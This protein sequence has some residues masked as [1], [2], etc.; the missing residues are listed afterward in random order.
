MNTLT[1]EDVAIGYG[2]PPVIEELD[3]ELNTGRWIHCHGKNGVGKSTLLKVLAGFKNPLSGRL[4][5]NSD[6]IVGIDRDYYRRKVRYFGHGRA[7]FQDLSVRNNWDLYS[8]LFGL[9]GTSDSRLAG[10]FSRNRT[11]GRLSQGEKHRV[12]LSTLW[13]DERP[14]I[15]MDEPFAS[16]DRES[17]TT[18]RSFLKECCSKDRLVVTASPRPIEGPDRLWELKDKRVH[19]Q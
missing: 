7:L 16:L 14:V 5:W 4:L 18:L 8:A 19:V 10:D 1:L 2:Y 15:L 12:E 17:Q 11:V 6:S 9:D 3:F 13:P